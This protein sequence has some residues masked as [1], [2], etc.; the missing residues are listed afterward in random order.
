MKLQ[1]DFR[2]PMNIRRF[3]PNTI[4]APVHREVIRENAIGVDENRDSAKT[5]GFIK[6]RRE[7]AHSPDANRIIIFENVIHK[8]K[9]GR[10]EGFIG[11][12]GTQPAPIL[13]SIHKVCSDP[14]LLAQEVEDTLPQ[15]K[16]RP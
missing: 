8:F 13:I 3:N 11:G 7:I 2:Q 4:I 14:D 10:T 16:W 5:K 6:P 1:K 9:P 12:T 15:Q